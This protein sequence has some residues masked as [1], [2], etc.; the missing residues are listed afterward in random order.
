MPWVY[1]RP[2]L[3]S[4]EVSALLGGALLVLAAR[5]TARRV[6]QGGADSVWSLEVDQLA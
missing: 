6:R 2:G 4:V 5:R 1:P 3:L